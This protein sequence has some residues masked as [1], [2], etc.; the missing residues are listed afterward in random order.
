MSYNAIQIFHGD[1]TVVLPICILYNFFLNCK[2]EKLKQ[3]IQTIEGLS[4]KESACQ[5]RR[6]EFDPCFGKIPHTVE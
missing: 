3:N 6:H 4:S 5:C 1:S 2:L